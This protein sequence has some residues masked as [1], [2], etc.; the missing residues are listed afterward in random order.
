MIQLAI[1]VGSDYTSGIAGIGPV[2][3][4]EI[5]AAFPSDDEDIL[6]GLV[7]FSTWLK[8]SKNLSPGKVSLRN[9]LKNVKLDPGKP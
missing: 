7:K 4:L 9:K 6:R 2:T 1:L 5:L 3:A 8:T